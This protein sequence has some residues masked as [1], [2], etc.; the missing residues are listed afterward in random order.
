[1]NS[2]ELDLKPRREKSVAPDAAPAETAAG[3]RT[4]NNAK[5]TSCA[6]RAKPKA[7]QSR[8]TFARAMVI[9]EVRCA[10]PPRGVGEPL[11][12]GYRSGCRR[13]AARSV[14]AHSLLVGDKPPRPAHQ[15]R[16]KAQASHSCPA[17]RV[18]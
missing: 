7:V 9:A 6:A 5:A 11:L 15:L 2:G 14:I 10:T 3:T 13:W 4:A 1:M 12:L 8:E 17:Q 18:S 16:R